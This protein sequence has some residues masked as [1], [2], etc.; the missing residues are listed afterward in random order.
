MKSTEMLLA[1]VMKYGGENKKQ[2]MVELK[3]LRVQVARETKRSFGEAIKL[4]DEL[5]KN[6]YSN[7]REKR[8]SERD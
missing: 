6:T 1:F 4:A 5:I 8:S 2:M 3:T 7:G